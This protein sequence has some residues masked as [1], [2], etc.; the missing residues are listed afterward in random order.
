[1]IRILPLTA[2]CNVVVS[3]SCF[4]VPPLEKKKKNGPS[5]EA[6]ARTLT[7]I[8]WEKE[9]SAPLLHF[10]WMFGYRRASNI[11][12]EKR[13]FEWLGC[14]SVTSQRLPPL[15]GAIFLWLLEEQVY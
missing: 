14:F 15:G 13:G 11:V 5:R 8:D 10:T 2:L 12:T 9:L 7:K 4:K 6:C 3:S 1:M